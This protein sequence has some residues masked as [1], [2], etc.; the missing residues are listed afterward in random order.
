MTN[1][2]TPWQQKTM[3]AALTAV[4]VVALVGIACSVVWI[5]VTVI[6]FL[7]PILIPV[8]IAVILAYLLD[9]VITFLTKQGLG[10]TKAILS[11]FTIAILSIGVLVAWLVS[12]VSM[13]AVGFGR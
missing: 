11:L 13:Q 4:F 5:A 7:Q 6:G 3:W 12:V 10:R 2:P 9:P 1:Y 8:A